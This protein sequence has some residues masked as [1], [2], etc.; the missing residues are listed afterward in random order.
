MRL[1]TV[2]S[3]VTNGI[4]TASGFKTPMGRCDF[5]EGMA[6][7]IDDRFVFGHQPLK[8]FMPKT[9][10]P[11]MVNIPI[12]ITDGYLGAAEYYTLHGNNLKLV[13]KYY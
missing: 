10:L 1:E 7:W 13:I 4:I 6:V 2:K 11:D 9:I 5:R 3:V 8:S 12:F